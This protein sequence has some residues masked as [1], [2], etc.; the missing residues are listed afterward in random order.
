MLAC[1]VR[2]QTVGQLPGP[3]AEFYPERD[4]RKRSH[5]IGA[6]HVPQSPDRRFH[7]TLRIGQLDNYDQRGVEITPQRVYSPIRGTSYSPARTRQAPRPQPLFSNTRTL[8]SVDKVVKCRDGMILRKLEQQQQRLERQT[9]RQ[10]AR[11][12]EQLQ[13]AME[14][15]NLPW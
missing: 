1:A 11:A 5:D 9:R 13:Q 6:Y 2:P 4:F 15:Q 7:K 3:G 14:V 12:Q 10:A 8:L